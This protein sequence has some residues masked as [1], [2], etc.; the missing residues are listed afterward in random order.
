MVHQ[1]D[2]WRAGD[3]ARKHVLSTI[4]Y[5]GKDEAIDT[6]RLADPGVTEPIGESRY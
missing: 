2:G 5:A 4:E 1:A 6:T 3:G